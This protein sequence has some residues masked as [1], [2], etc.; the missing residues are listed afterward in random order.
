MYIRE[1]TDNIKIEADIIEKYNMHNI[2]YF[3]IETTGFE[4]DKDYIILI[5]LGY[6]N[7]EG[8]FNI[9]QYFAEELIDE[10]EILYAFAKDIVKF[11]R[12]CSYNGVAF[13]EP[14]IAR[15]MGKNNI[16]CSLPNEHID[17]YR[18]IRPYYKQLGME[19]CNLKTVEKYLGVNREDQIDGGMS[20]ELY[21]QYL[22]TKEDELKDIIMLHNYEDVLNLPL[23]FKIIYKVE[24]N[25]SI[26]REDSI[27]E[28]QLK[29]LKSLIKKNNIEVS[30]EVERVSKKAASKIIDAILKGNINSR[31]ISNMVSSSY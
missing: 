30:F 18:I 20:V 9:K 14:F 5:S 31:E 12:W 6:Y 19:R 1:Y 13:D 15:R 17:L 2:A 24:N 4:K 16:H 28:K 22:E 29:F 10:A 21:Y 26:I 25:T 3:D 7:D 8:K 11:N 23:I 27:T